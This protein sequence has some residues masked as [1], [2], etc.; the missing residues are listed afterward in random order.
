[1]ASRQKDEDKLKN[2]KQK[3]KDALAIQA[4]NKKD[5]KRL[6]SG[7]AKAIAQMKKDIAKLQGKPAKEQQEAFDSMMEKM[8][9]EL[10]AGKPSPFKRIQEANKNQSNEG[11]SPDSLRRYE[12]KS[13]LSRQ[14]E[15]DA[16]G[17]GPDMK[18]RSIGPTRS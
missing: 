14:K 13:Q 16:V 18:K 10:E 2:L 8:L 9:K 3:L 4:Q 7:R 11:A 17:P 15:L 1:M 5:G 6:S 12:A